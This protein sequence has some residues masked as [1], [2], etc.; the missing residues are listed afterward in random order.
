MPRKEFESFTRLDA[1]DVNTFLMDQ[2]V[3]TFAGTAARGSAID[4]ATEGMYAHLNDSDALTYFNGSA[5]V[6]RIS[7]LQ[8]QSTTKSDTFSTTATTPTA[9]TGA[10]VTITP[11]STSS[12]IFISFNTVIAVSSVQ[13][14]AIQLLRDSTVIGGGAVVGSRRSSIAVSIIPTGFSHTIS[15]SFLDSPETT[16]AITYSLSAFGT[17]DTIWVGRS[18]ADGDTNASGNSR[19]PLTITVMEVA[20]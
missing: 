4:T 16:S 8:V 6:N 11:S 2:S 10:S 18:N 13:A 9:I 7:I 14:V 1:S 20:G 3:M 17:G 5:W 19:T 12:K 15:G